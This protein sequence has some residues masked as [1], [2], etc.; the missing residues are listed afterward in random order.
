MEFRYF[1][2]RKVM[3]TKYSCAIVVFPGGYGTLDE[4]FEGL[5]LIQ[6]QRIKP[7]PVIL[8]VKDFWKGVLDWLKECLLKEG[9]IQKE[10][11]NLFK[12]VDTAQ[13]VVKVIEDFYSRRS[14]RRKK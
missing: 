10:D 2:V 1:F 5:A 13:Q 11:L 6:T 9:T 7:V 8:V 14:A 4:L 12:V 3:F